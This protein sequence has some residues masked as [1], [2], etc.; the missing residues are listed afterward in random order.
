[1][2][3]VEQSEKPKATRK[4]Q[5][6]KGK[7]AKKNKQLKWLIFVA[8]LSFTIAFVFA[9]V[10]DIFS[11]SDIAVIHAIVIAAFIII[12]VV[13]ELIASA[14][15]YAD[16]DSFNAMASRKVK[17]AKICV[18]FVN[19]RD[20]VSTIISDIIGDICAILSGAASLT[21]SLTII[22]TLN[23]NDVLTQALVVAL[24]GALVS[25]ITILAKA[26][27]KAVAKTKSTEIVFFV[28]RLLSIFSRSGK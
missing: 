22:L 16:I 10:S 11:Q 4:E 14:V 12:A 13:F 28:G 9:I 27:A 8:V 24:V 5:R 18:M 2:E 23:I 1:M 26:I 17:G 20:K 15:N 21:L 7:Y 3:Q 25:S 6:R 19:N